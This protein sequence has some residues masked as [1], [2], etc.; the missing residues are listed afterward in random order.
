MRA[1]ARALSRRR[2]LRWRISSG[3]F[4]PA[5]A[6]SPAHRENRAVDPISTLP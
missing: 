3:R 5:A 4:L 2:R 1:R 6:G